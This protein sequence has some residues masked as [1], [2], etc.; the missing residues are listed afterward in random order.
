MQQTAYTA[1]TEEL[2]GL[3]AEHLGVRARTFPAAVRK[4]GRLLPASARTAAEELIELEA[5]VAHPKLAARTDPGQAERAAATLR[6]VLGRRSVGN[7][8]AQRRSLL[9][10]EIGFRALVVIVAGL[11]FAQWQGLV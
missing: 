11:A 2:R 9:A 10:A 8:A 5:R 4:A 3:I 6:S 1:M 7:R